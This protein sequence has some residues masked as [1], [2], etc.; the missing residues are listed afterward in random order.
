MLKI[1]IQ[2]EDLVHVQ[3]TLDRI[4][5]RGEAARLRNESDA[6]TARG[7]HE[8]AMELLAQ[9]HSDYTNEGVVCFDASEHNSGDTTPQL[10][11]FDELVAQQRR[12]AISAANGLKPTHDAHTIRISEFMNLCSDFNTTVTRVL[13]SARQVDY[14]RADAIARL[15]GVTKLWAFNW[16][17]DAPAGVLADCEGALDELIDFLPEAARRTP[18]VGEGVKWYSVQRKMLH[19]KLKDGVSFT[20]HRALGKEFI[21][22]PNTI[23]KAIDKS[24][25]LLQWRHN[26]RPA[27]RPKVQAIPRE[28]N[29]EKDIQGLENERRI[30]N[31]G[32]L[33]RRI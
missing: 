3:R 2:R 31:S 13:S 8:G 10:H 12:A 21:C 25:Q 28:L 19:S 1:F 18:T 30:E 15:L 4:E 32:K 11:E 5:R 33:R 16:S 24:K 9:I 20:S 14:A 17:L 22:S 6:M 26:T 27:S 29:P 23:K 7:E